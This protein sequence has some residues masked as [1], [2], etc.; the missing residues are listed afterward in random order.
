MRYSQTF[1]R[2][3][4]NLDFTPGTQVE[5]WTFDDVF[6]RRAAEARL[7]AKDV[8]ARIRSALKPLLHFFVEDVALDG[9]TA[10]D[11]SYPVHPE[12]PAN[13][14]LLEAY[15]L[16]ALLPGV[17]VS[18]R[19]GG[20]AA[21]QVTLHY[22]ARQEMHHVFAPNRLHQDATGGLVLSP[23]GWLR[24]AETDTRIETDVEAVFAAALAAVAGHDWDKA[25]PFFEELNIHVTLPMQDLPLPCG[26]E[27]ISLREAMHED[28]YFSVLEHFQIR[29]G[30]QIGARDL[31]PGQIVPE[32]VAGPD[33]T[34]RV[35][36]RAFNITPPAAKP[37]QPLDQAQAPLCPLQV[38]G[39]LA[40]LGGTGFTA[41]SRSNRAV[42]ARHLPGAGRAVMI[43]AGQHANET[44]GVVGALRAAQRLAQQGAAFTI[45]PLENPDGYALHQ[46]LIDANPRHMHHAARYTALGDDLE[47]RSADM[48]GEKAIRTQAEQLSGAVLHLNLHG[49]PA[50]EWIRPFSGYVPRGFAL[51]T[52]PKGF[53]LIF[54][55]HPGWEA[56]TEVLADR[57][58]KHLA[59]VPGLILQNRAQ[60]RLYEI[61]AGETGFR[62]INGFPCLISTDDRHAV[63]LTL[64]T[65][66]VDE[67]IYGSAFRMAHEAQMQTV[68]AA[69]WALQDLDLPVV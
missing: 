65:E 25:E 52:L 69:R 66:A 24:S 44:T 58:T 62:M 39:E 51:W 27:V 22:G 59:D 48:P 16:P 37:R 7:A 26:D 10:V 63:P 31:R 14:F 61:H 2:T 34:L 57:V 60:I 42:Q 45:S 56:A 5:I 68:L 49:Y 11:V 12:A 13:R 40:A 30:R 36:T 41:G 15:P 21:Y 53:F 20:E 4:D 17:G 55:H 1:P 8:Q 18:F 32:V 33:V 6:A 35:E 50:H 3:L 19:P 64:I 23:T 29:T 38:A 67:T 28:L 54:R 9:L 47:Y 43:S 46:R